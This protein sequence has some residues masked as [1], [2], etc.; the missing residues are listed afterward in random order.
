[1]VK[2]PN[3]AGV[4][5][6]HDKT[7]PRAKHLSVNTLAI[8]HKQIKKVVAIR[9]FSKPKSV[10]AKWMED[11]EEAIETSFKIDLDLSKIPKFVKDASDLKLTFEVF[12]NNYQSL[13]N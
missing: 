8:A 10:F 12:K 6:I 4:D 1:M 9:H 5:C 11:T 2:D 13:R 3:I 7:V